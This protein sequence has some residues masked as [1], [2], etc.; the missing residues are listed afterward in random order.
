MEDN[1]GKKLSHFKPAKKSGDTN[2]Q[3][4]AN[5]KDKEIEKCYEIN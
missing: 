3:S 2:K 1:N 4:A 5:E